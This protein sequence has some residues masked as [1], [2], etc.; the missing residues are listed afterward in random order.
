MRISFEQELRADERSRLASILEC[1]VEELE[2]RLSVYAGAALREYVNMFLGSWTPSRI[3]DF[4]EYRLLAL[5]QEV[6]GGDI[7]DE[8]VVV[9]HFSMTPAQARALIRSVLSKHQYELSGPLRGALSAT[10]VNC[11]QQGEDGGYEVVINNNT[12]VEELNRLL[13]TI[14]GRLP[15][16]TKKRGSVSVYQVDISSY[17]ELCSHLEL[18]VRRHGDE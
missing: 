12:V 3:S 7:P 1:S 17:E 14:N 4:H 8:D 11:E 6:F 9:R 13:G 16:I 2:D 18:P 5:I 10:V 15:R